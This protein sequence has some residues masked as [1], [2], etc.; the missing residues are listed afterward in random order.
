LKNE[1]EWIALQLGGEPADPSRDRSTAA[2]AAD[3]TGTADAPDA[4]ARGTLS[5]NELYA[6]HATKV[7]GL[8]LRLGVSQAD[9]QDV[10]QEVFI[11]IH[12]KLPGFEWRSTPGTWIHG[13]CTRKAAD[14]RRKLARRRETPMAGLP[15][16]AA[17]GEPERHLVARQQL[18]LLQQALASL[19]EKQMQVFVLF[20][21][22]QLPMS[23]VVAILGC[24]L[25]TG[26][27]RH[28]KAMHQIE[29]FFA[30][31]QKPKGRP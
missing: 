27:T 19:P 11:A 15:D 9:V 22:E 25:F 12:A 3:R 7:V 1:L 23:E 16:T 4:A 20:E 26:Y 17:G 29:S 8:L 10:A 6:E 28:S 14:Y 2:Q 30:K 24:P 31:H 13:F 21:V 5:F 18:S